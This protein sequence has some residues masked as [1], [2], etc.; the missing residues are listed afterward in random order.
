MLSR[1]A[2]LIYWMGRYVERAENVARFVDVN[3]HLML[4]SPDTFNQ[5]QP[6][7]QISGDQE[8]FDK[9][10]GTALQ[11]KVLMFLTFDQDNPNSILSCLQG[12]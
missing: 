4:D 3:L 2:D 5:W 12:A 6:F 1:V 11:E 10:Y 9:R 7:V 8:A